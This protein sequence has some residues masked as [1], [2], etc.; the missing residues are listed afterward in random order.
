MAIERKATSFFFNIEDDLKE[1]DKSPDT[2]LKKLIARDPVFYQKTMFR[3]FL[4]YSGKELEEMSIQEYMDCCIL[5]PE[6]LKILHA[7]YI[8][9][10]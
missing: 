6:A 10:D 1:I 3:A 8:N 9:K 5:L 4:H 7:P 2:A